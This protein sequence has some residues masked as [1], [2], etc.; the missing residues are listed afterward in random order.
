MTKAKAKPKKK[1]AP[2]QPPVVQYIE[3][4]RE[5][6]PGMV[7]IPRAKVLAM[8]HNIM[9]NEAAK[10][11]PLEM[12]AEYVGSF[13]KQDEDQFVLE[14]VRNLPGY[15]LREGLRI[16]DNLRRWREK[17]FDNGFAA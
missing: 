4:P 5:Q 1:P 11:V 8:V 7:E 14:V 9:D 3:V 15:S 12:L 10:D 13:S 17:Y 6:D 16:A 2:S